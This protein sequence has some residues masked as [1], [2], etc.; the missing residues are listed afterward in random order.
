MSL[1]QVIIVRMQSPALETDDDDDFGD[2]MC[3]GVK[4]AC[5]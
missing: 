2:Y 5:P 3:D 1:I 4:M